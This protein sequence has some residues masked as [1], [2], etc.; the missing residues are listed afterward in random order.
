MSRAFVSQ[1]TR[2]EFLATG[3]AGTL[4]LLL[5]PAIQRLVADDGPRRRATSCILLWLN[6]GPSHIDTFDPKPGAETNGP[7]SAID[8]QAPGLQF[9]QHLPKLAAQAGRLAVIRSMTSPEG[10]HE[11]AYQLLH[12]GNVRSETVAYP[13]LGSVVAREWSAD[14]GDLPAL[15]ALNGSAP[16]PGFFGVEFSPYMIGNLDAPLE[17]IALPE[18]VSEERL[19]RRLGA[20]KKFNAASGPR[21][22]ARRLAGQQALSARA[23]RFRR[24]PALKAFDLSGE[25][26]ETLAAYGAAQQEGSAVPPT[27]GKACLM[28]RRLVENGVRFVEVTLDGWDTHANNFASVEALLAQ[29]DPA[30]AA[31]TADLADRGLL[32]KTLVICMGEFGRTP[33][34]NPQMGR[35]HWSDAFSVMLAGGGISGGRTIGASDAKGEKVADRPV[36]VPDLYAT[37]LSACGIDGRKTFHTP[38]GRPIKLAEKGSV[39]SELFG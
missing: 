27:F 3:L 39:V 19:D 15:V 10:D 31:L 28:A 24:S 29:L 26:P 23:V 14:D 25:S 21:L 4:G 38:S 9:S 5:S 35:D 13:G 7:F 34:I 16:G 11:R 12:T 8:T 36:T 18:G 17:N 32:E 30:F 22:D 20:L 33:Q 37:L 6:G 1:S 2:R